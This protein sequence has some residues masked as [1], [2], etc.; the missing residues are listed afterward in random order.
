MIAIDKFKPFPIEPTPLYNVVAQWIF[1]ESA[2]AYPI[3][4]REAYVVA[5]DRVS[6]VASVLVATAMCFNFTVA[7]AATVPVAHAAVA[8][9]SISP[10][11]ALSVFGTMQSRSAVCAAAAGVAAAAEGQAPGQGCV[12]PVLDPA[13]PVVVETTLDAGLAAVLLSGNGNIA[14][15]PIGPD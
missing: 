1:S 15:K 7:A 10:F 4:E 12:L 5:K 6:A 8:R 11:V 9:M 2:C 14:L 3:R 13:A